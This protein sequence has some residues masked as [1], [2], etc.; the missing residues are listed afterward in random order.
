MQPQ[1]I[2]IKNTKTNAHRTFRVKVVAKGSLTGSTIVELM[3]GPDNELSY[4]G[5]AF[6]QPTQDGERLKIWH[7]KAN[8]AK[9]QQILE[10]ALGLKKHAFESLEVHASKNCRHCNRKLTTPESIAKGVGP[11]CE[12]IHGLH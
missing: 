11:E 10:H 2:T 8:F 3:T 5:F 9:Y 7:S 4:T 12:K 1:T 6:I